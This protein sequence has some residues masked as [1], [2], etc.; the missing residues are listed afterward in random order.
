MDNVRFH[1]SQGIRES[2]EAAEHR[3]VYLP[4]YSPFLNPIEEVFS[5]WKGRVKALNCRNEDDL[6][7]KIH[8]SSTCITQE[9]CEAYY[10]HMMSFI[11]KC[12]QGIE[13]N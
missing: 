7:A 2:I 9:N 11:V 6:Y 10:R 3:L 13:I 12:L 5:K 4:P 8:S 1:H